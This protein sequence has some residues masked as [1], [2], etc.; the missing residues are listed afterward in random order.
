M[1]NDTISYIKLTSN[2]VNFDISLPNVNVKFSHHIFDLS[3]CIIKNM[4][5][6]SAKQ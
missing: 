1:E 2:N 6:I 5:G 4:A 3:F